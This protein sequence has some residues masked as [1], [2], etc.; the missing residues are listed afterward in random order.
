[1]F[2]LEYA[3][4]SRLRRASDG[5]GPRAPAGL[6]DAVV[7]L[8]EA[9]VQGRGQRRPTETIAPGDGLPLGGVPVA[10]VEYDECLADRC[11]IARDRSRLRRGEVDRLVGRGVVLGECRSASSEAPV[12]DDVVRA[13]GRE[14]LARRGLRRRL[15]ASEL[16][17]RGP[18]LPTAAPC[19]LVA[20]N[21]SAGFCGMLGKVSGRATSMAC[22]HQTSRVWRN[23]RI[24]CPAA[25]RS[26]GESAARRCMT[27]CWRSRAASS[28]RIW[29]P[30]SPYIS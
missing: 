5:L 27:R 13:R 11:D 14:L 4:D 2:G 6:V 26:A 28:V 24:C 30:F 16:R 22:A 12:L 7:G 18:V 8:P 19:S 20:R 29:A 3:E 1:M 9:D 15:V 25:A 17:A 21:G 23:R 10:P